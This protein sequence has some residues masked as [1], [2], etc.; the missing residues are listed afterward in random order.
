[1][2]WTRP[3][4]WGVTAVASA[5]GVP[6]VLPTDKVAFSK[7]ARDRF[8]LAHAIK[9]RVFDGFFTTGIDGA[10]ALELEGVQPEQ[11][12]TG[13]YPVDLAWWQHK[14]AEQSETAAELRAWA[15]ERAAIV[16]AVS[17]LSPR[18]APFTLLDAFEELYRRLPAARFVFVGAGPLLPAA[19]SRVQSAR[20]GDVVRLT[21]YVDYERLAGVYG[22]AD[23][24]V[25]AA[26]EE[27]WGIS[28]AEA[29]ACGVPVVATRNIG[30]ARH[31]VSS[32]EVGVLAA[33]RQASA[34][35]SAL[36]ISL[37]RQT[38]GRG[39]VIRAAA[40]RMDVESSSEQLESLVD[41]ISSNS[42]RALRVVVRGSCR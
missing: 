7:P 22:A 17:K 9:N 29:L 28:V 30:A 38:N 32:P 42:R 6:V 27:P 16:L 19:E 26:D 2:G 34:I 33:S 21:G 13:L 41:R 1:S 15:G 18:E 14:R 37:S 24:F 23:V 31:L 39:A 12:A 10:K 11:I 5:R 40:Q 4:T 8:R 25:H 36:E 20:L 35:A 3:R